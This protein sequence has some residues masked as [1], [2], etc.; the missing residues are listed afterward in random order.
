MAPLH[1]TD[2]EDFMHRCLSILSILV[3]A[4]CGSTAAKRPANIPQPEFYPD[5]EPPRDGIPP[6]A[7]GGC[8]G[9]C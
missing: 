8:N 3:L 1:N 4:A 2:R 6:R 9:L 5:L 7:G